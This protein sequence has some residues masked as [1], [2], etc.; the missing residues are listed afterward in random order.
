MGREATRLFDLGDLVAVLPDVACLLFRRDRGKRAVRL[1]EAIGE[2][3]DRAGTMDIKTITDENE[4]TLAYILHTSDLPNRTVFATP[5][6]CPQQVGFIV[7]G[8][9][10]EIA[11]HFHAPVERAIVGTPEV[12]VLLEGRCEIDVY[13]REQALVATRELQPGDVMVM[14]AGGHGFRMLEDTAM[15]EIKQGPYF[16][17]DEKRQF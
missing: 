13:D 11:R 16:G 6:D 17:P 2:R 1:D 10:S 9:G 15:L 12:L 4:Q 14:V 3:R 8:A 5:D 7:H